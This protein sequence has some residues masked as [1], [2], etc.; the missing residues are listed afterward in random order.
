MMPV[1]VA[2]MNGTVAG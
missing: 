2:E 1:V